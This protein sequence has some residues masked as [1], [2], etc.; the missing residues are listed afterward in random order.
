[1]RLPSNKAKM[2]FLK[3]ENVKK[4][5]EYIVNNDRNERESKIDTE[6]SDRRFQY[7]F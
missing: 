5:P 6:K 4:L 3:S 7:V 1:M 2:A